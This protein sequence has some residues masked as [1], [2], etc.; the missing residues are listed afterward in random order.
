MWYTRVHDEDD[1]SLCLGLY[2]LQSFNITTG[3][4]KRVKKVIDEYIVVIPYNI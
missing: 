1:P 2:P 3:D 4:G